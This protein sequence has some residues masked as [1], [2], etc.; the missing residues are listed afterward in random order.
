[1][2]T[3]AMSLTVLLKIIAP[4]SK[5][6]TTMSVTKITETAMTTW[7]LFTLLSLTATAAVA[8]R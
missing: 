3:L 7:I 5:P 1:M 8:S 6:P 4:P 2:L